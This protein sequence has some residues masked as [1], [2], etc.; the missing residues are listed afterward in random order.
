MFNIAMP[1]RR[2]LAL[3]ASAALLAASA[4]TIMGTGVAH[5][6][7]GLNVSNLGVTAGPEATA[8]EDCVSF[9]QKTGAGEYCL[10]DNPDFG[11]PMWGGNGYVSTI[12][13]DFYNFTY[14]GTPTKTSYPVRNDAASLINPG[15]CNVTTWVSP[16]A[17]GNWNWVAPQVGGDLSDSGNTSTGIYLRNNEASIQENC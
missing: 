10:F 17:V 7:S 9:G 3:S 8:S 6:S 1:T 14:G 4:T 11:G 12:S 16:N 15:N 5:A 2:Q 13:G